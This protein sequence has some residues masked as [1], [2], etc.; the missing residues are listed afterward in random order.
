MMKPLVERYL[1]SLPALHRHETARDIGMHPPTGVVEKQV[2]RGLDP[3]SQVSIVFTGPFQND[4]M[5][6]VVIRAMAQALSGILHSTLREE[7][8][9]TYGVSVEPRFTNRPTAE[10][11]ITISFGCDPTRT[12]SLVRTA[13]QLIEQFKNIGPSYDQVAAERAA[14][15]RDFETNS[16]R[17]GYLLDR[18]LFKYEYHEDVEDVF[19]MRRFYDQLTAPMLR[20]AA[21]TYLDTKRYVKVT[22]LPEAK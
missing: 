5:H 22:L 12:E 7:L 21:R 15:G 18:I 9:G 3:K 8:G 14:L 1:S 11:R 4:E 6:R 10:Y 16:Q 13:F 2:R 20:D 19:N 17:N